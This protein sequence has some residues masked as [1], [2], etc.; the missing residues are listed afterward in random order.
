MRLT[1]TELDSLSDVDAAFNLTA[2]C[3]SSAWVARMLEQRPFRERKRMLAVADDVVGTLQ[4]SDWVEAFSHHPRIG[5][6]RAAA[7][8]PAI[9]QHWSSGE[10]AASSD[11]CADVRGQIIAANR[12]YEKRFGFIFIVCANGRSAAE[13]HSLLRQRLGNSLDEELAIAARE[14]QQITRL[15]L[16][17]LVPPAEESA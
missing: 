2:C 17:K 4:A 14:Q 8:G 1:I 5:E 10:Q 9:A 13:I 6:R 3:G 12:E 15:R 16:E 7:D 11:A